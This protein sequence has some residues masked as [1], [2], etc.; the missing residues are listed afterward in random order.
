M[1]RG[2]ATFKQSDAV[3]AIKAAKLAG[4]E[5]AEVIVSKGEIRVLT[6]PAKPVETKGWAGL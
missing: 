2:P 6:G 4:L 1:S 3:K 5:V